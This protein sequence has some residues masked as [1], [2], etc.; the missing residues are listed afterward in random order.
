MMTNQ[1]QKMAAL[2][3]S[4]QQQPTQ[5]KMANGLSGSPE[6]EFPSHT[7]GFWDVIT[8]R[9]VEAVHVVLRLLC[10]ASSV[11]AMSFM[12]TAHEANTLVIY[13]FRIPV[14]SK[15]SYSSSFQYLV[16][17][18]AAVAAHT[19]L[20]LLIFITRV[21]RKSPTVSSRN[22]RWLLFAADQVFAYALISAG[23]AASGVTN[24][25][26]TGIKHT[27]LPNFCKP[28]R[29]FCDHVTLSIAFTFLGCMLMATTAIL[30]V[31][32]LSSAK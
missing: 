10:L 31:I 7:H 17:T 32:L 8:A 26:R 29:G 15:W 14:Q 3:L 30:D 27:P 19:L 20:Q 11:T 13:G 1:D 23:S 2:D 4:M 9:K 21:L 25:N 28:L 5:E 18:V 22:F 24:L 16:G 6:T 12:V